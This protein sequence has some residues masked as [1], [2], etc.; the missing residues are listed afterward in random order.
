MARDAKIVAAGGM[1]DGGIGTSFER[2]SNAIDEVYSDEGTAIIMDMG[3]ALMTTEMVIESM[4]DRKLR[5]IDC[6]V[7]EGAILAAVESVTGASLED[8]VNKAF[9]ARDTKKL[10][11]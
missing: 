8:I 5:M 3:S 2:I 7:L 9:E 11:D 10:A 1:D 6:P 4:E